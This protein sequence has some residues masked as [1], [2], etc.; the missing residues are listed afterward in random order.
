MITGDVIYTSNAF[1]QD[2]EQA[3][4]RDV[5]FALLELITNADDAYAGS[6]GKITINVSKP[7]LVT[8]IID[9]S[10]ADHAKGLSPELLLE[11]FTVLGGA[12]EQFQEEDNSRGLLGRGAKD[13][14]SLGSVT[15]ATIKDEIYS[16]LTLQSNGS[17]IAEEGTAALDEH[18][19][20]LNL[21]PG[22]NGLTATMHIK[23][24]IKIPTLNELNK[25]LSSH[26]QLRDLIQRREIY[27]FDKRTVKPGVVV[28]PS[29][30]PSVQILKEKFKVE[31]YS[32]EVELVLNRMESY[33]SGR[34]GP[35]TQ[36][37]ILVKS[38]VTIYE[39]TGFGNDAH[40][41]MGFISGYIVAPEINSLIRQH[42]KK[43]D[44]GGRLIRRDREGLVKAHPYM[45]A[46]T[47]VVN[48]HLAPVLGE[49]QQENATYQGQGESLTN[50]LKDAARALR[51]DVNELMKE[52]EEEVKGTG[53]DTQP[54]IQVIPPQLK[55]H[56]EASASLTVRVK[57]SSEASVTGYLGKSDVPNLVSVSVPSPLVWRAH[58][59][60]EALVTSLQVVAGSDVGNGFVNV[61]V[62]GVSVPVPVIVAMPTEVDPEPVTKLEFVT[63][64]AR[65][66]PTKNRKLEL[67]APIADSDN[68]IEIA[69][70]GVDIASYPGEV[71]LKASSTGMW[72]SAFVDI[73]ASKATGELT[74]IATNTANDSAV[75]NLLIQEGGPAGGLDLDFELVRGKESATRVSLWPE[76]GTLRMHIHTDHLAFDGVF[77]KFDEGEKKYANEDSPQAR[78]ALLEVLSMEL[79]EHFT[80]QQS[81]KWPND[82]TDGPQYFARSHELANRFIKVFNNALKAK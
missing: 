1:E 36:Q 28:E 40:P 60:L 4:Q 66:A 77:G 26:A 12:N 46:L 61:N 81:I 73:K 78:Q 7:D 35:Y 11:K 25:K 52:L 72:S 18:R 32:Q 49:I 6:L 5:L 16:Y 80:V 31:G 71:I 13:V 8:G 37:G 24:T 67:R 82:F 59:R 2:G 75:A 29:V 21:G 68:A 14:A 20:S 15:F 74:I 76:G 50:A 48:S 42:D 39:N 53:D 43:A 64:N 55:I 51:N 62:G 70:S 56:P 54:E 30:A 10:V 3:I 41:S 23:P 63:P 27:I 44:V 38:G 69:V 65:I 17:Y 47:K 45:I 19:E 58:E 9:V 34:P 57:G 22:Q 33:I 79:G